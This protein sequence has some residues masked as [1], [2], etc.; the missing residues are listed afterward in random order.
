MILKYCWVWKKNLFAWYLRGYVI[1]YVNCLSRKEN[2]ISNGCYLEENDR[3]TPPWSSLLLRVPLIPPWSF[4]GLSG[5]SIILPA[6]MPSHGA[7]PYGEFQTYFLFLIKDFSVPCS[8]SLLLP[9]PFLFS[10]LQF[11][12]H[13]TCLLHSF[14]ES[15]FSDLKLCSFV[16]IHSF[17]IR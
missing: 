8:S 13:F 6:W 17:Y 2:K 12:S 7:F 16:S 5:I 1:I 9:V 10:K 11:F 15:S 4:L 14:D 3:Q